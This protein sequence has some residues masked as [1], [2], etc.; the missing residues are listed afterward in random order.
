LLDFLSGHNPGLVSMVKTTMKRRW[1]WVAGGLA[2]GLAA[3]ALLGAALAWRLHAL[4]AEQVQALARTLGAEHEAM[5]AS[6]WGPLP[7]HADEAGAYES[8]SWSL[9]PRPQIHVHGVRWAVPPE[10]SSDGQLRIERLSLGLDWRS[11]WLD[12]PRLH[13]LRAQG[14]QGASRHTE[15]GLQGEW[16]VR[17]VSLGPADAAGARDLAWLLDA[18]LRPLRPADAGIDPNPPWL[19]GQWQGRARWHP[20]AEGEPAHWREV[21]L[22]FTGQLAGQP[23]PSARITLARWLHQADQQRLAWD[24]LVLQAQLG[25]GAQAAQVVLRSPALDLG[26]DSAFGQGLQGSWKT[27]APLSLTWKMDSAAPRGRYSAVTW[28]QWRLVPSGHDGTRAGGQLQADLGWV[29]ARR[30]LRWDALLGEVSVQP[31]GEAERQW[32]VRGHMELGVRAASWQLEGQAHGGAPDA[33]L[34]DGPFAA[35]GTWRRWPQVQADARWHLASL[36]PDRWHNARRSA[37]WPALWSRLDH[38]PGQLQLHVGQLGWQGLRLTGA[39]ASLDVQDGVLR[40]T[41]LQA[42]LWDGALNASGEWR[43]ADGRWQLAARS[44]D[45]DLALLRQTLAERQP[46]GPPVPRQADAAAGRWNGALS[47]SGQLGDVRAWQGQ[48]SMDARAGHWQGVDLRAARQA[49]DPL[50]RTPEPTERTDWR[51]LQAA[52]TVAGGV[53][54]IDRFQLQTPAG[55]LAADG[56]LDLETGE[57]ALAWSDLAGTRKRGPVLGMTGP[58]RAPLTHLP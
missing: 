1:K 46:G 53:A 35:E 43:L 20:A 32:S 19:T 56:T 29:P 47:L 37:T 38:W 25:E 12:A 58:W 36:W 39:E 57:L 4:P 49:A 9:W 30:A 16:Q 3:V 13:D 54:H 31:R 44:R 42:R 23:V 34:W 50:P 5:W 45:A 6:V 7:A 15:W 55:R 2:G 8:L 27:A 40:L 26:P 51:R 14:L 33:A 52:G 18:S 24:D 21:D 48:W 17:Q 11:L 22:N 28:P 10:L 41:A